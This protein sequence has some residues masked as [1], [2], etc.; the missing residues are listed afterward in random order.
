VLAR[1]AL[2]AVLFV[3]LPTT[4]VLAN[5][6][7][8]DSVGRTL[9]REAAMACALLPFE[10]SA[11]PA[12][13]VPTEPVAIPETPDAIAKP[14]EKAGR[15]GRKTK[16]R[17]TEAA[18]ERGVFV[19]AQ[20]VLQLAERRAVPR[21]VPVA[22]SGERPAGL[23]L[24]GVGALGIGMRDGD[25]LTQVLGA[26]AA[27]VSAVVGAIIQARAQNVRVITGQFWRDGR[28]LPIAV[29]QPYLAAAKSG[30]VSAAP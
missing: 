30:E 17:A 10:Q 5:Q 12:T 21:A 8:A 15:S 3:V 22:A 23:R 18:A 20:R 28:A 6:R 13:P 29:E 2:A 4:A 1:Y 24:E 7:V 14:S 26:P 16:P 11:P 9:G 27:S 19:S 25:I